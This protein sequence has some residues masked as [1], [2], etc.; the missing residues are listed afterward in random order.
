M[1]F[2][3][4]FHSTHRKFLLLSDG[5]ILIGLYCTGQKYL[6]KIS[7]E[8]VERDDLLIFFDTRLQIEE[9][10]Q[11]I[12]K[13][14]N[15]QYMFTGTLFQEKV[16]KVLEK[17][18]FGE[19]ATYKDIAYNIGKPS[20]VRAVATAISRNPLMIIIPCHRVIGSDGALKGYVAG[21]D[22]KKILL[23]LEIGKKN[24]SGNL[25]QDTN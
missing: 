18:I 10:F 4:F 14:F 3:S 24:M 1:V 17:M 7:K 25:R 16:W 22:L 20:S 23:N 15:I 13:S 21:L 2:Y 11:G 12:R 8:W 9:Y 6:P 19:T 5:K